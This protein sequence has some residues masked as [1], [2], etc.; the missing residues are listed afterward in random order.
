M[1][2]DVLTIGGVEFSPGGLSVTWG[3]VGVP[4]GAA[5]VPTAAG[6]PTIW[7]SDKLPGVYDHW[8]SAAEYHDDPGVVVVP[9]MNPGGANVAVRHSSPMLT[10]RRRWTVKRTG[11][12]PNVPPRQ[13]ADPN[14]VYLGG[15]MIPRE[16]RGGPDG[17][18]VIYEVSG[19]YEYAALDPSLV[20]LA[21]DVPPFIS[22]AAL[23][24]DVGW[25]DEWVDSGGV[26]Q[27]AGGGAS[28]SSPGVPGL[29]IY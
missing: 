5:V 22:G 1:P 2:G 15:V 24:N 16:L 13:L 28:S 14:W 11:F 19:V 18:S 10:L 4:T 3:P 25:F 7:Y 12:P 29:P 27:S 17:L 20:T 8:M 26:P 6:P 21:A 23:A 9:A